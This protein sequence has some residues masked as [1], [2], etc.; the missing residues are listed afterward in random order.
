MYL[1]ELFEGSL[2]LISQLSPSASLDPDWIGDKYASFRGYVMS[3]SRDRFRSVL[4]Y[5]HFTNRQKSMLQNSSSVP[6]EIHSG[7]PRCGQ[8]TI[9]K[10]DQTGTLVILPPPNFTFEG[11]TSITLTDKYDAVT[12]ERLVNGDFAV[13]WHKGEPT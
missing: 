11:E 2:I 1:Y 6:L 5:H 9:R 3:I 10:N 13:L 7:F 12:I 8:K 4:E